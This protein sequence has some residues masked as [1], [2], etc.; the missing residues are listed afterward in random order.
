MKRILRAICASFI[1]LAVVSVTGYLAR[2]GINE[3]WTAFLI[4]C[5]ILLVSVFV[6]I[7]KHPAAKIT[8]FFINAVSMGF[9][10]RSWYINRN[11]DNSII[12][13]LGIAAL[14]V[15][16][17]LVFALPLYIPAVSRHYKIYLL[18]F[19]LLS[20]GGYIALVCCTVTTWVSTLGYFG[21]L[22][23]SFIMGSSFKCDDLDDEIVALWVSSYSIIIC[24]VIILIV[25]LAGDGCDGCDGCDGGDCCCDSPGD[26]G[27]PVSKK[28]KGSARIDKHDL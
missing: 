27:S 18:V 5:G 25:V 6:G 9:F 28:S 19:V 15:C 22:Q 1:F 16:Y 11:F 3:F 7:I 8:A 12:L 13:M 17:M 4:G 23:L 2:F 26:F 21:L 14:A 10:L 20:L 24:A